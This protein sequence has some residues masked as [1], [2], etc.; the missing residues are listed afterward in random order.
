M[1]LTWNFFVTIGFKLYN[2]INLEFVCDYG[3]DEFELHNGINWNLHVTMGRMYGFELN[4]SINSEILCG[5]STDEW[6]EQKDLINLE[7]LCDDGIQ[8]VQ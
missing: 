2:S 5:D 6:I 8:I 7:F 1:I 3:T 4:N